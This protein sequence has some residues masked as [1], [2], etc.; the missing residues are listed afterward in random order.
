[1]SSPK[2]TEI[3]LQDLL[4][5]L[6]EINNEF[7]GFVEFKTNNDEGLGEYISGLS[8]DACLKNKE[9]GFLIFGVNDNKEIVGTKLNLH[10]LN[11][12]VSRKSGEAKNQNLELYL[13]TKALSPKIDFEFFHF[14]A[15]KKDG[16]MASIAMVRIPAAKDEPT[17]F[18]GKGFCR[19][20]ENKTA[21]ANLSQKQIKK[22]YN[23]GTDWSAEIVKEASFKDL[24]EKA[25]E[26]AC[27]KIIK[28]TPSL[29]EYKNSPQ[30]LFDKARITLN[31][32]ITRAS[33]I[34]LGK[35]ETVG[36][37][38]PANIEI[39]H[40]RI[41]WTTTTNEITARDFGLPFFL[42]V[43]DFWKN[44]RNDKIKIFTNN[45]FP[46]IADKYD[47]EAILEAINNCIAH[48][49]YY[50]GSRII[51]Y[52]KPDMLIFE[53]VGSF[54]EGKVEDYIQGT[55]PPQN[56]RNYFLANAMRALDMIDIHGSGINKI[57][58]AQRKKLFPMPNYNTTDEEVSVTIYGKTID[59]NFAR[60]LKENPDLDLT[61]A[62]LLDHVQKNI[63]ITDDAAKMLKK[64]GFIEGRK[65]KYFISVKIAQMLDN[66]TGG[67]NEKIKYTKNKGFDKDDYK[68]WILRHI[69]NHN[70]TSRKEIDGLL[71][72]KLPAVL[73]EIQKKKKID[74]LI[75]EMSKIDKSIKNIGNA[76][77][78]KWVKN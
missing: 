15:R 48:Q 45:L 36:F 64:K 49:D 32:K 72:D 13:R 2:M 57:Y 78:S 44:I 7:E 65:P 21:L 5:K 43:N 24:D 35:P 23:S 11:K 9:F 3:E 10:K 4:T 31:G 71:M 22:I 27:E 62:V 70:S 30:I 18:E 12:I 52:E 34:L 56:Y 53:S 66:V 16:N 19:I 58:R 38:S 25:V 74:N 28:K 17:L 26:L 20:N 47:E 40:K 37:L 77:K 69:E 60:I 61:S 59:D 50:E 68:K 8:N 63:P 6:L 73:S 39:L 14:K 54:F 1:M 51:V 33:L 76:K 55:K 42:T 46:D 41:G 29:S 67:A 75:Q